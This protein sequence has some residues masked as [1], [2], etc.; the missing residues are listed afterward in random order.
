[1]ATSV[2]TLPLLRHTHIAHEPG[3]GRIPVDHQVRGERVKYWREL[4]GTKLAR[5]DTFPLFPVVLCADGSPWAPACMW[6]F[7][8]ARAKPRAFST[9]KALAQDLAAYKGFLDD[10]ALE[11]DDFS[12][13]DKYLRPTYLYRSHLQ[14]LIDSK[15]IAKTT[16]S[17]R[18]SSAICLYKFLLEEESRFD[19]RPANPPWVD[20][21]FGLEI[22]N[23][24][25]FRQTL[26]IQSTDLAIRTDP[27]EQPLDRRISDD[28]ALMPLTDQEQELLVKALRGLGNREFELMHYVA[29][30]TGARKQTVLTLRWGLFAPKPSLIKQWPLHIPCGP[31][32][33]IDTKR[34]VNRSLVFQRELYELL[35]V[36]AH[37][38]RAQLRRQRSA[39]KQSP[40]NYLFITSQGGP[41]YESKD[42][43]NARRDSSEPLPRGAT[44][45]NVLDTFIQK[46]VVPLVRQTLPKFDY[47]FHDL[48]ATFGMNWVD[49]N[50]QPDSSMSHHKRLE[51]LRHLLWHQKKSTTEHYLSYRRRLEQIEAAE[52]G[53]NRRLVELIQGA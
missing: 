50:N 34:G 25:G 47:H 52:A 28:G 22:R 40:Q 21:V 44:K 2:H 23:L 7:S 5:W 4:Q 53:W 31:G 13:V 27:T 11:W 33:G 43:I 37:S 18:M 30:F 12:A 6:L 46:R 17:R 15:K 19:F 1:M 38:P 10:M 35:H 16:A 45:G 32:T 41:Y 42:D 39:L 9:L 8:R 26:E 36:Y 49:D 20:K 29:L 51:T 3:P 14:D 24:Q 48:R